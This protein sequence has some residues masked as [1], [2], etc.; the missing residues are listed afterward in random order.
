MTGVYKTN[1]SGSTGEPVT[2]WKTYADAIWYSALNIRELRWKKWDLKN[3]GCLINGTSTD[4]Q[5]TD[6]GAPKELFPVQGQLSSHVMAP[7]NVL[8]SW[9]EKKNPHYI[10]TYP[11]ILTQLDLSRIS[12]FID[13]KNT[14]EIGSSVYSSEECGYIA[15]GCPDNPSVYHTVENVIV[16]R[17]TD[18]GALITSLTNPYIKRYRIGDYVEFGKC[19]CGRPLQTISKVIG[20]VR[21]M[22]VYPDGSKQWPIIG[23]L[24]YH[25]KFQI[26]RFQALQRTRNSV[27]LSIIRDTK[28]TE[29]EHAEF[30]K[31]VQTALKYPF[32]IIVEYVNDFPPGKFEEFKS[33]IKE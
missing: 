27:Q 7:V 10:I 5:M 23:S 29:S 3:D 16:E 2:V 25:D 31:H 21:N 13:A 11:S 33:L 32:E 6:W 24:K 14:G 19:N 20:R 15:I 1:S 17:E 9:L 28:F 8:Q 12:N 18:G 22:V 26:R 30:V 4:A